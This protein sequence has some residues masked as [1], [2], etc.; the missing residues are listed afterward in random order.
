MSELLSE[1]PPLELRVPA[2]SA[3]L[4]PGFDSLGLA[5]DLCDRVRVRVAR[6]YAVE[7][8]GE[9][10]GDVPRGPDHLIIATLLGA[11]RDLGGPVPPAVALEA[12]NAIPH[13]R[14][15]GS[16]AA[17][18][19]AGLLAAWTW[20]RPGRPVD[21]R[22][23]LRRA[24]AVEGH[25]DNAAPALLGG[26]TLVV[27]GEDRVLRLP[28]DPRVAGAAFVP[29]D[30]LA[31]RAARG[32]LPPTVPHTAAAANAGAAGLLG[33]ALAGAPEELL[34]ATRDRLHQPYR[35]PLMPA[36]AALV[37]RLRDAGAAAVVSGA[38]PTVVVLGTAAELAGIAPATGFRVRRLRPGPRASVGTPGD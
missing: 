22:W 33:H 15:L 7:V 29:G 6:E 11:L 8:T 13:A 12:E 23:L 17:A 35:A 20:A 37:E 3:N 30:A 28:L 10:A 18:V 9:G 34:A 38:G 24:R 1:L 4:G 32:V 31:T 27:P 16:S 21:E 19:V 14:G 36:S 5:W 2:T 25:L 26:L